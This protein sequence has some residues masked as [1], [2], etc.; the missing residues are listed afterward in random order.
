MPGSTARSRRLRSWVATAAAISFSTGVTWAQQAPAQQ[1]PQADG[2]T[3]SPENSQLDETL[4]YQ[5]LIGEMELSSGRAG[6]AFEVIL[7]AARRQRD[8]ALFRRAIEIALQ[9][10]AA[11]QALAASR[12]WRAAKPQSLEAIRYE[13]QILLALNRIDDLDEPL[14]AWLAAVPAVERP[15]TIAALP[16]LLQRANDRPKALALLEQ[17]LA[18]HLQ[19]AATRNASLVALGR[20]QL[21]AG[22]PEA[23]LKRLQEAHAA[24]PAATGPVLLAL[25]M[26]PAHASAELV[27]AAHLARPDA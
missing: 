10:R 12:A 26:L 3:P 13:A 5:L 27:V 22:Q 25:D 4:F 18:P 17:L 9:G 15:G 11:S 16:R 1:A 14:Q 6:S 7:D 8:E 19:Q 21:N 23:A 20:A 2:S 24:D